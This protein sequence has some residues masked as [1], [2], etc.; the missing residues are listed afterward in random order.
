MRTRSQAKAATNADPGGGGGGRGGVKRK[1]KTAPTVAAAQAATGVS[2]VGNFGLE[3]DAAA[4]EVAA[5]E[6]GAQVEGNGMVMGDAAMMDAGTIGGVPVATDLLYETESAGMIAMEVDGDGSH[7]SIRVLNGG[8]GMN[9]EMGLE[10]VSLQ[11]KVEGAAEAVELSNCSA[12]HHIE[13]GKGTSHGSGLFDEP[14]TAFCSGFCFP[15][16]T[17]QL[18]FI[19]FR[20]QQ[21]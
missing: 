19:M 20:A 21:Q 12:P 16:D 4:A 18:Y 5:V 17:V 7:V 2:L 8:D 6:C 14:Y 9:G 1:A 15:T 11:S 10:P 13:A 3:V